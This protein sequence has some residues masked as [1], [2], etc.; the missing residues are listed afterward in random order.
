MFEAVENARA[1]FAS[2]IRA[3]PDEIAL[4]KNVSEG[5]NLLAGSLPW[6]SGDSVVLCSALEHPNNVFPWLNLGRR[7]G[8]RVI[9]VPPENGRIPSS[10]MGEAIEPSTR[11]VTV[12][13][14]TFSPGF[15]TDLAPLADAC[16]AGGT[17]LF[18]DAA[19]T[20]G[21]S[22]PMSGAWGSTPWPVPLRKDC[23]HSTDRAFC[24]A[25]ARWPSPSS[26]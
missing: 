5:V 9:D 1:R 19:Q 10:R 3:E 8:V 24:T 4:T 12:P 21:I 25:G 14:A 26:R 11:L 2:L 23:L 6:Q 20:V 17:L 15:V 13:T 16:A 18:V 7:L 22:T